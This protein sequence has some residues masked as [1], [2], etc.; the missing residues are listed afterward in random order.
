MN[1]ELI[2]WDDAWE[3]TSVTNIS[4]KRLKQLSKG[5]RTETVG[6]VIS[7]TPQGVLMVSERW[8]S[9]PN[10]AKYVTF[11]PSAMI[12]SRTCLGPISVD[13]LKNGV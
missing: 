7:D 3:E 12:V 1:L 10:K 11:I 9:D 2:T 5:Y 6:F 4:P 13:T 8:P